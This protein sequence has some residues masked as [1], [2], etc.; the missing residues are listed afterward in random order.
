LACSE[1]VEEV[2]TPELAEALALRRAL[3]LAGEEGF[4]RLIVATDC[5]SLVQRINNPE[6]D[7]SQVGVV[8]L[9]IKSEFTEFSSVSVYHVFRQCNIAAHT[10]ARS[11]EHFISAIFRN[12]IPECIRQTICNSLS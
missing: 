1:L 12:S 2:T 11:A 10:L 8:V 9:D 3:V 4:D 6:F 7:R 5:L